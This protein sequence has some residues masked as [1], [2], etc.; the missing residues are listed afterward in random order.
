METTTRSLITDEMKPAMQGAFPSVIVTC[1]K[2]G[3]PNTTVISQVFYVDEDHLA[4]SFQFFNKTI[5]NARENPKAC[6]K[7]ICP[8]TFSTFDLEIEYDHSETEGQV[9]E[10]MDMQLEAIASMTGMSGVFKLRAADI[11]KVHNVTKHS[12]GKM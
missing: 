3:I 6:V 2:S 10:Q 1:A 11:Y 12:D 4:L 5:R 7:I 9:F 8:V